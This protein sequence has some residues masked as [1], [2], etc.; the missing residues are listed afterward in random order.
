MKILDKYVAKNFLIGYCI[1]FGVLI[2]MRI[3]IDLFGSLGSIHV[4]VLNDGRISIKTAGGERHEHHPAHPNIHQ[5]L[6]EDFA[7]ALL[8]NREPV[9]GGSIGREVNRIL[10]EV[11]RRWDF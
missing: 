7:V 5:P 2:G 8:E 10:A 6:I 1:A 4:P 9:V 11:Y 3:T